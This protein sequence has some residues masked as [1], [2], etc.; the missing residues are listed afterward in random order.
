MREE[1]PGASGVEPQ[2]LGGVEPQRLGPVSRPVADDAMGPMVAGAAYGM[3]FLLG[4]VLGVVGGFQHSWY[5]GG[6]PVAALAWLV[7]L[8]A[9]PYGMGR[10]MGGKAGALVPA[11]GWFAS[12]FLLAAKQR[13]G[14]LVIAGDTSGFWYL[15]G[16]VVV[17]AV[18]VIV[19]RSS[20]SWLLRSYGR[21]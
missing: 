2:R 3:L 16:G 8:F 6:V 13:A 14:D 12:S 20:G 7:V 1:T 11:L 19:T 18:A 15:Y 17:L 21:A 4:I 9:V 10:L 5:V